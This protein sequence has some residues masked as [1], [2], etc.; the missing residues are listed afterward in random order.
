MK[1]DLMGTNS[2]LVVKSLSKQYKIAQASKDSLN[3][4]SVVSETPLNNKSKY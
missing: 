2:G 1:L 3:T 4:D